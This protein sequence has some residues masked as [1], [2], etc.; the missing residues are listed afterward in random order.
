MKDDL[1][2][3]AILDLAKRARQQQR[4]ESPDH[5]VTLDNP[6]CGDRITLDLTTDGDLVIDAGHKTRGCLLCEAAAFLITDH[7]PGLSTPV[8]EKMAA[9]VLAGVDDESASLE[10]L[11]PGLET[12][13]PVRRY[14]SRRECVT[15]PFQALVNM[16]QDRG[17]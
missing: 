8:L 5:T 15:L 10:A 4:L 11:W 14:K 3:K 1:Y 9:D 16:L 7:A 2:Q 12:L 17:S 6:L 13:A